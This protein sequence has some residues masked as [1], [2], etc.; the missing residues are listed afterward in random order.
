[1]KSINYCVFITPVGVDGF[2][3]FTVRTVFNTEYIYL[4]IYN[5]DG[6]STA[7]AF[8]IIVFNLK[9]IVN[10]HKGIGW[11]SRYYDMCA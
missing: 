6:N 10:E 9:R 3:S 4:R 11:R 2:R 5:S 7:T 8:N 1:M